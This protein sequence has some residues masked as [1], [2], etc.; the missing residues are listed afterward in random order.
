MDTIEFANE[1]FDNTSLS[2]WGGG[3]GILTPLM[4]P[5]ESNDLKE[6]NSLNESTTRKR[7]N[8]V[9]TNDFNQDNQGDVNMPN[10]CFVRYYYTGLTII[11]L[12]VVFR[13]L[14]K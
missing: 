8:L 3:L 1:S 14:R 6:S 13:M 9:Q 4:C 10:D 2:M 5:N 12:Y 7:D 11:G